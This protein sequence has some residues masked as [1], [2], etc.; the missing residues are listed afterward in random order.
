MSRALSILLIGLA[1]EVGGACALAAEEAPLGLSGSK[2]PARSGGESSTLTGGNADQGRLIAF[3]GE[4]G[5]LH[6]SCAACHQLDGTGD[7]SGAFPRLAQ[8]AAQYLY[9]SLVAFASGTRHSDIMQPIAREL[10][11]Q[12]MRDVAAF[13]ATLPQPPYSPKL[14]IDSQ[15]IDR[16]HQL[17]QHGAASA[18]PACNTCH[19]PQG[20]GVDQA[21]PFLAG[22]YE[23][24]LQQQL[25]MFKAGK[26]ADTPAR[27]MERVAQA[28]SDRQIR[29]VSSYYASLAPP[30]VTPNNL[31]LRD[32]T[33]NRPVRE[34]TLAPG[35]TERHTDMGAA[36]AVDRS[37]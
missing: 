22:Q 12:Q 33:S 3:G 28:L 2:P 10:T 25:Q 37:P 20:T 7:P 13:Y 14:Q 15:A 30:Q 26:R 18:A 36:Q 16:G 27:T 19:G 31:T 24:Y 34:A 5:Q 8:Q 9:H 35:A 6:I 11:E 21:F 4:F 1:V 17:D 29:D 23:N 32:A